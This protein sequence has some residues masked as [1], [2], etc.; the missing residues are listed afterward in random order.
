MTQKRV[1]GIRPNSTVTWDKNMLSESSK[2]ENSVNNGEKM[3]SD[4]FS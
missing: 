2:E 1:S 4:D 3:L